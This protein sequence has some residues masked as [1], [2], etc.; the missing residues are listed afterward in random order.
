MGAS[1]SIPALAILLAAS[2]SF[3]H[4]ALDRA[5]ARHVRDGL[6]DYASIAS[7]P[8]LAR[9]RMQ[10]READPRSLNGRSEALAFWINAYNAA[11]LMGVVD[12]L[13]LKSVMEIP[14]EERGAFFRKVRFRIAGDDLTLDHIE[15][16]IL[17]PRFR[18]PRIHFALVCAARG[19]PALRAGAWSASS[20]DADLDAATR[21]FVGDPEKV[22]LDP[23]RGV[24][25]LSP[26]FQWYAADFEGAAGDVVSFVRR[27]SARPIS[28]SVRVEYLDYSWELNA[29]V[30]A[31]GGS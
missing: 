18:D 5:L 12:R 3:S 22:R 14:G 25:M 8:D 11:V 1:G 21:R 24:L 20:I 15:N 2:G 28:P 16:G 9:Y 31:G 29:A 4:D 13:P 19:C 26:I 23:D 17:R 10:L 7:D 6:V 30:S 27:Y